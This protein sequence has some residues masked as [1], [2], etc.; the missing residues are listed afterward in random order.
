M[1][2]THDQTTTADIPT[3]DKW[4]GRNKHLAPWFNRLA[5]YLEKHSVYGPFIRKRTKALAN[6]KVACWKE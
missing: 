1:T 2:T 5:D 3:S 4:Q 6:G